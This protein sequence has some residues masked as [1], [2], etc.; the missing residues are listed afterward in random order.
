M[1]F[2]TGLFLALQSRL[3]RFKAGLR[4][5]GTFFFHGDGVDFGFLLTEVL[6][7]RNIAWADPGAGTAFNT[8]SQVMRLGFIVQLAFAVPVQL[9]RQ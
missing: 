2:L 5:S 1:A 7:Q 6:H 8:V 4:F 3:T 9:L